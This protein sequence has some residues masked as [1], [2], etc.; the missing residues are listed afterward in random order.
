MKAKLVKESLNEFM[1]EPQNS[2]VEFVVW[3]AKNYPD[4]LY[5]YGEDDDDGREAFEQLNNYWIKEKQNNQ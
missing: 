5:K 1:Y 3:L 2:E 4:S